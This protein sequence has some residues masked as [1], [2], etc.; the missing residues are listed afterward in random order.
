MNEHTDHTDLINGFYT[1]QKE[2]FDS[3]SQGVYAFLDEDS[4]VC[5]SKF[6]TMLGYA[7]AEEWSRVNVDDGFPSVFVEEKSQHTLVDA[8]QHAM[9]SGTGATC[10]IT[11]KK[12]SGGSIDTTVILVPVMYEGHMLALHY[13]SEK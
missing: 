7:S 4:R 9:E 13:V 3:S 8:Y 10:K 5:N 12:K 11:W 6:A 2:I 1:E